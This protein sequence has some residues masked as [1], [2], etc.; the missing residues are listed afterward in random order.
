M[1]TTGRIF[2]DTWLGALI[3]RIDFQAVAIWLLGF[4]LVVYLGLNGGGYDPVVRD[5]LGIAVW[6]GV[7]LGLAVGALPLRKLRA[8]AWIALG[9]LAAYVAWVALS[10]TWSDTVDHSFADLGRVSTYLGIFALA[11]ALR[12]S[13][14]ARRMI[15]ALGAAIFVIAAVGLLSRL[16]PSW[17]PDAHEDLVFLAKN[18]SRL[19]YP[20]GYWN[21]VG[22]LVAIGL[23]L[24]LY[25]GTSA[26]YIVTRA[27]ASAAL[28]ALA[29]TLYFTFSR[30][31]VAAAVIGLLAFVLLAH[32]RVAK[33]GT[34]VIGAAGAAILILAA[35]QRQALDNGLGNQAA[36]HQGS[37]MLAMTI[38]VCAGVGLLAAGLEIWLRYGSRPAWSQPSRRT[39]IAFATVLGAVVV[40]GIIGLLASGKV[41]HAWNEFK[42]SGGAGSGTARLHSF[43]SNGRVPYWEEALDEFSAH[44]LVGGGS[45]SFEVWWAQH[46]GSKGGFVQDAHSLYLETLG[47]LGIVGLVLL[48]FFFGWVLFVGLRTYLSAARSRRTQ[49]AAALAGCAAFVVGAAYDW[50]WEL[51]VIPIA[52]LLLVSVLVTAGSRS[53]RKPVPIGLRVGGVVLAIA[54]MVAIA[55]PLSA[56]TSIQQ[57]Q[58]AVR[59]GD[60]GQALT[61]A[62]DAIRVE[63]FA[64]ATHLQKALVLE[65][66]GALAPAAV[67]AREA[68]HRE[69]REWRAWLVLSRLQAKLG[70][71]QP[72]ITSYKRAR[73]LNPES[74]LFK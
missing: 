71:V 5:Q 64:A 35:H 25:V 4:L 32:D 11:L 74:V 43:S 12:G 65:E 46:R 62:E 60:L 56:A 49:L 45:G 29:L 15:S 6:W 27:L 70:E 18:R 19:S 44:P 41:S 50:L 31:G 48:L 3:A 58:A 63:P 54:A 20:L 13:K 61:K 33:T 26:R 53:R 67:A 59:S 40:V 14:G 9:A 51:P 24:M 1:E 68:V 66:Q 37:E 36:H 72:A 57:S 23:P 21:G 2:G 22:A 17:F 30:G 42:N 55:I 38:V 34:M 7:L 16:H 69:P 39:S 52:F 28:P 47:E 10:A 8:S 73:K